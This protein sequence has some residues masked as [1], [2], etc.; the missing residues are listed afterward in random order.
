MKFLRRQFLTGLLILTP[1]AVTAWIL[2]KVFSLIDNLIAPIQQKYPIIDIPGLGFI[3]VV[4]IIF[5]TGFFAGNL[6][7]RRIIEAGEHLL[8]HLPIVP[9]IYRAVKE[10]SEVFFRD[11]KTAFRQVVLINYPLPGTYALAFVTKTS[12]EYFNSLVGE[13]LINVFIPTTPNPT[14]G[15]LLLVPKKDAIFLRITVEEGM[16]MVISGGAFSP[17]ILDDYAHRAGT[18]G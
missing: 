11:R 7:G 2:L 1:I 3:L 13:P 9:R 8:S 17:D 12:P 10:L 5:L 6:L 4:L 15:F 14:S 16:K 18:S